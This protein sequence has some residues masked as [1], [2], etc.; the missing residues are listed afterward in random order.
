MN[1]QLSLKRIS[2]F[3]S[4]PLKYFIL[5]KGFEKKYGVRSIM[6]ALSKYIEIPASNKLL[7]EDINIDNQE[8]E[9]L[10]YSD[11]INQEVSFDIQVNSN[12]LLEE[13]NTTK[14]K[15]PKKEKVPLT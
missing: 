14:T 2:F 7:S 5:E 9:I 8:E 1:D 3:I 10:I 6:R 12:Q 13:K 15:R 11:L 4:E